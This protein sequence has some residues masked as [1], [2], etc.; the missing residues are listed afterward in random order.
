MRQS[1]TR[2]AL[3]VAAATTLSAAGVC[4]AQPAAADAGFHP[5]VR[6]LTLGP[7]YSWGVGDGAAGT[8]DGTVV[9]AFSK[10]P[11][12][13]ASWSGGGMPAGL[14]ASAGHYGCTVYAGAAG[15]FACPVTTDNPLDEPEV[16]AGASAANGT[17]AYVGIAYA[18]RGS[19]IAAAVKTAQLAGTTSDP[20]NPTAAVI[21]V[22]TPAQ[23]AK[24]NV[25]LST[26][27]V[28]L[29]SSLV[30]TVHVHAEDPG[31]LSVNFERTRDERPFDMDELD[32]K[33]QSVDGGP[34]SSCGHTLDSIG[35]GD[36]VR[37]DLPAGEHTVTY[38]LASGPAVAAWKINA[39][40]DFEVVDHGSGNPSAESTFAVSS[41]Y[42]VRD[43][44]RLFARD[45]KGL[46]R[47]YDGTGKAAAPYGERWDLGDGWQQ[48][49]ALSSL[50]PV[51]V[52][53]TGDVVARDKNG[54]L[55]HFKGS[56]NGSLFAARTKVGGG[57]NTYNTL[58]GSADVS[59]DGR[60]DLVA[61]D[62][63]GV[64]WLY[65]G[66][67]DGAGL[68]ASRTKIGGG[69]NTY[70]AL[71]APGD[72]TGDGRADLLGRDASGVLWLYKGTGNAAA[73]YASR[74]KIGGGW[75]AYT[76]L[77]GAG[78]LTSDG[79][80]DLVARDSAGVLWLYKGTGNAA[81]P[82]APR[83]RIGGGWNAYNTLF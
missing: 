20:Q 32:I 7:G 61:R 37:C 24:S 38:T 81:A 26:P 33:V 66:T 44:Y 79:R 16:A 41:P 67:G 19:S 52:H 28:P 62:A 76:A 57:W 9:Y 56:A 13:D 45:A 1:R 8:P 35:G 12:T 72:L 83:T 65:R 43:R 47:Y 75:N 78:D 64:L 18:P 70:T 22:I 23:A 51:T 42:P 39:R 69:W 5:A 68:F 73:P 2:A 46:L 74:T 71:T 15:V 3:V 80:S 48:Y 34:G 6:N 30:Q 25:T 55:W 10:A 63:S 36:T 77:T 59:G 11:L 29:N 14:T 4:A 27:D 53:S 21:K 40:A 60:S 49:T 54:V 82:Y 17:T 50:G 58:V 31:H